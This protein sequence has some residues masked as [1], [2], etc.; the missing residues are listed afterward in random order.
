MPDKKIRVLFIP[1]TFSKGGGAERVLSNLLCALEETDLYDLSL[2]EVSHDSI[3]WEPLPESVS[4][5]PPALDETNSFLPYRA[6]RFFLRKALYS[7]SPLARDIVRKGK[8]F[9][10]VVGFN[11]LYPTFLIYDDET[12]ISWNH[13]AIYDLESR[14]KERE[15][16]RRAYKSIDAIV[17][18]A[19]RTKESIL[20]LYPEYADK[21]TVIPN[22]FRFDRIREMALEHCEVLDGVPILAI[23]RLDDNKDPLRILDAF[24]AIHERHPECHLYYIGDGDLRNDV[25]RAIGQRGLADSATL[26]GYRKNPYAL[27]KQGSCILTMSKSEGFQSVIVEGLAL[28]VPFISTPVGSAEELSAEG[29]FGMTA[30]TAAEA[31]N[32]YDTLVAA[33]QDEEW[34]NRMLSFVKRY[35]LDEQVKSFGQLVCK[36]IRSADE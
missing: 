12:S 16:Q 7:Y 31:A 17:A 32:A 9:D 30:N 35:S 2:L 29:T 13:G 28:G 10:V 24:C 23:G 26:L 36:L 20:E 33:S 18:I 3:A 11:Y 4:V 6:K 21:L 1:W 27:I 5:L 15:L 14:P 34:H 8:R 22:G 19:Q 25:E